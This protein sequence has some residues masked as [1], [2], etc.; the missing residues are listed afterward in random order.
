[1]R[2]KMTGRGHKARKL[3]HGIKS[4]MG[5]GGLLAK[6]QR[7]VTSGIRKAKLIR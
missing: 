3:I 7:K 4:P 5:E 6:K 1:M 2:H